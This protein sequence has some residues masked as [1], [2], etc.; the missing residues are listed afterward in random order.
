MA[1]VR[2]YMH[3]HVA[4][5]QAQEYPV[6]LRDGYSDLRYVARF[7]YRMDD[8]VAIMETPNADLHVMLDEGILGATRYRME[9]SH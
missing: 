5:L 2:P 7:L 9:T 6:T 1:E 4:N 8:P 3:A